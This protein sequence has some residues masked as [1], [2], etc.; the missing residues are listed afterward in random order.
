MRR[1]NASRVADSTNPRSIA[2]VRRTCPF[3]PVEEPRCGQ[4]VAEEA[5]LVNDSYTSCMTPQGNLPVGP[6]HAISNLFPD[7]SFDY[8]PTPE[9]VGANSFPYGVPEKGEP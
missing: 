2:H 8:P 3:W 7:G 6:L 4:T 9:N 1:S 5:V